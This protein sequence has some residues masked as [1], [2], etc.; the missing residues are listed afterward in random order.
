MPIDTLHG[1]HWWHGLQTFSCLP[2][3]VLPNFDV[4]ST[5]GEERFSKKNLTKGWER[6][7]FPA[8]RFGFKLFD[9]TMKYTFFYGG[10]L[11]G[12]LRFKWRL[13]N[14]RATK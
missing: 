7:V 14:D 9:A 2:S 4:P 5:I 6:V 11:S 8:S 12:A 10:Y 3:P 1:Q 13:G